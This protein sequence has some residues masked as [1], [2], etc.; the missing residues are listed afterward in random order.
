M[1]EDNTQ[2]FKGSLP[3][4]TK[5]YRQNHFVATTK[6]TFT[7]NDVV[8]EFLRVVLDPDV[9]LLPRIQNR[10]RGLKEFRTRLQYAAYFNKFTWQVV[11]VT[12]KKKSQ[13][14]N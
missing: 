10:C 14:L 13:A 12:T 1:A 8:Y 5:A 11:I 7:I 2:N 3:A 4:R 6:L 9:K